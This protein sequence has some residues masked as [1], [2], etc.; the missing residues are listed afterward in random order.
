M[1]V[2][3]KKNIPESIKPRL[4]EVL[5]SQLLPYLGN[6]KELDLEPKMIIKIVETFM[7]KYPFIDEIHKNYIYKMICN[8]EEFERYIEEIKNDEQLKRFSLNINVV[9]EFNKNRK[10]IDEDDF[11]DF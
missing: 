7:E 2:S 3:L 6:M 5:F 10:Y 1:N 11:N 9:K 4:G 8:Q